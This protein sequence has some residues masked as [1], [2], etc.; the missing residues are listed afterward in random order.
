MPRSEKQKLKLYYIIELFKT[1]SSEEHPLSVADIID[2]LQEQGIKA[3]RKSIYRDIEAMM[4]LG[5]D[6]VP[7]HNKRFAYYLGERD[8]QIAEL[9]LLVDAVQ[10]SRFITAK[11]SQELIEKLGSLVSENDAQKLQ[12][13]VFVTNRIK[14]SNESIYYMV[15]AIHNAIQEDS[16]I[17][18]YYFDWDVKKEKIFRHKKKRYSV[19]PWS[20][21]WNNEN[22]YLL[23]YDSDDRIIK[24]YRVDRMLSLEISHEP[25]EGRG[26]FEK[27][28]I[29]HYSECYFGMYSGEIQKVTLKCSCKVINAIIDK[30][31]KDIE[32]L[33][34]KDENSFNVN[35]RVAVS[36]VF[37]S[38][39]FMFGGDVKIT[40]PKTVADELKNMALKYLE[41]SCV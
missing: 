14:S 11:K 37:F 18:F 27:T 25:R 20:L 24:H 33:P 40:A 32:F 16:K 9:R 13:H 30:F 21:I 29:E 26:A 6:I 23:G 17:D 15:D 12:N 36:P 38:W 35:V 41:E 10:A 34:G 7:V 19:S 31:G 22:Y 3:E 5:M 39:V 28:D 4:S 2:Y 1:K 8:F